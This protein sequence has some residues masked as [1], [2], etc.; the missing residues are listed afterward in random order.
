MFDLILGGGGGN[1]KSL[2]EKNRLLQLYSH[3]YTC[4][5]TSPTALHVNCKRSLQRRLLIAMML[6][7]VVN[8]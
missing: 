7:L 4:T 3:T 8:T 2:E 1:L 6:I 5:K